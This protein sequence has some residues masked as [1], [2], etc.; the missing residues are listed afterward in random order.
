M[1]YY[2][3]EVVK[4]LD[5][6][7]HDPDYE[8]WRREMDILVAYT[9]GLELEFHIGRLTGHLVVL[10][11]KDGEWFELPYYMNDMNAALSLFANEYGL[12]ITMNLVFN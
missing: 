1:F 2:K 11:L 5:R 12:T 7:R 9:L 3:G 4:L 8:E 10:Y 6:Y